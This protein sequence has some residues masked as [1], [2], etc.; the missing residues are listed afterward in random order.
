MHADDD[1]QGQVERTGG[2]QTPNGQTIFFGILLK[3][4]SIKH[5]Q[6]VNEKI[7]IN[8]NKLAGRLFMYT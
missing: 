4:N 5:L 8:G 3:N 1:E 6:L 7:F 2:Q